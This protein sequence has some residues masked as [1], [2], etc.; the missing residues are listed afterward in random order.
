MTFILTVAIYAYNLSLCDD[1]TTTREY[2]LQYLIFYSVT[3]SVINNIAGSIG[4]E[5]D[6]WLVYLFVLIKILHL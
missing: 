4:T 2:M 3:T 1:K 6:M 5:Y